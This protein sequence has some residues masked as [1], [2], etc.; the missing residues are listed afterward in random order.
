M[1]DYELIEEFNYNILVED[2][3]VKWVWLF[4]LL[5]VV[6][7]SFL[8]LFICVFVIFYCYYFSWVFLFK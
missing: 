2:F 1:I 5:F 8:V 3:S 4:N 7:F 6:C